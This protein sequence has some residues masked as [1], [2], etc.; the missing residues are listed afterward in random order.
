MD[1][2]RIT[3]SF[4]KHGFMTHIF[5]TKEDA[6]DFFVRE[7]D[8]QTIGFGG[9]VTLEEMQLYE[10]LRDHNAVSWHNKVSAFDVR[11]L[12]NCSRIYI[13]SANAVTESGEI[14]NIDATGNRVAMTAFGPDRCYNCQ[15]DERICRV[16]T[17][18]ERAPRSMECVMVFV[19][20]EL[21]Y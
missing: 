17:I 14:V 2:S 7:L 11:R 13:T 1:Y 12:A 9:S 3:T 10:A 5:S 8:K 6:R 19:D 18:L 20:E 21:G 16:V 4:E 15:G